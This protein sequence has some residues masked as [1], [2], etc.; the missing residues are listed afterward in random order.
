MLLRTGAPVLDGPVLE[1]GAGVE[2]GEDPDESAFV[3]RGVTCCFLPAFCVCSGAL[4]DPTAV[5]LLVPV[6]RRV[7]HRPNG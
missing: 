6:Y 5:S 7:R 2:A 1:V 3:S 4:F